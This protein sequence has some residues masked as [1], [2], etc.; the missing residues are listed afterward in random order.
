[1]VLYSCEMGKELFEE[2]KG[3]YAESCI[4]DSVDTEVYELEVED[5]VGLQLQHEKDG[6]KVYMVQP[7]Q[8]LSI[9]QI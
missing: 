8:V 6:I 5:N 2:N 7:E 9:K 3:F 4:L 1:M